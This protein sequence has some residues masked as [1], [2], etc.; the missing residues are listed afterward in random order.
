MRRSKIR[1]LRCYGYKFVVEANNTEYAQGFIVT[2]CSV[3]NGNDY[4]NMPTQS[5]QF[6]LPQERF[7]SPYKT[8]MVTPLILGMIA[9]NPGCTNIIEKCRA[10]SGGMEIGIRELAGRMG[11][12]KY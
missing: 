10:A 5:F 12:V 2:V 1:Q 11:H 6:N 8:L 7:Y 9:D 4:T 3:R